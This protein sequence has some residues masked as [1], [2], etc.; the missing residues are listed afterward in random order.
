LICQRTRRLTES[1][2][3]QQQKDWKSPVY[4]HFSPNV[5]IDYTNEGKLVYV[6]KC[7]GKCGGKMIRQHESDR[8]STN[9]LQRHLKSCWGEAIIDKVKEAVADKGASVDE[10]REK[11]VRPYLKTGLI[12]NFFE[13]KQNIKVTYSITPHTEDQ[14]RYNPIPPLSCL[15]YHPPLSSPTCPSD[16]DVL[17]P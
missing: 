14:K 12:T 4:A 7:L 2:V 1:F 10:A 8:G 17:H 6:F 11:M 3:A 9:N 5:D 13:H 16:T 15:S